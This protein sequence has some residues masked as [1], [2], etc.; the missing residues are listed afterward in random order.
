MPWGGVPDL[1]GSAST[2]IQSPVWVIMK[3]VSSFT[4]LKAFLRCST[5]L[6]YYPHK[7]DPKIPN[8]SNICLHQI[9]SFYS[10]GLATKRSFWHIAENV[11]IPGKMN[12]IKNDFRP[13]YLNLTNSI[14]TVS[15]ILHV[16]ST[17]FKSLYCDKAINQI[18]IPF[19]NS[20]S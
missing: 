6:V 4:R 12:Y 2:T 1:T 14:E 8:I 13:P 11:R 7:T 9:K 10:T 19:I 3:D 16:L 5:H 18:F 17:F 15:I 20:N